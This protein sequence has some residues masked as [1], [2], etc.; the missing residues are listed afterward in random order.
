MAKVK[1][2]R[3]LLQLH[4]WL[5]RR[6]SWLEIHGSGE[7][8][9]SQSLEA[10]THDIVEHL[11]RG[12]EQAHT[13]A[14]PFGHLA[15]H[16]WEREHDD[17]RL[18]NNWE[19]HRKMR[20]LRERIGANR[21]IVDVFG[22]GMIGTGG[23]FGKRE[24]EGYKYATKKDTVR[25]VNKFKD[26][27]EPHLLAN[28]NGGIYQPLMVPGDPPRYESHYSFSYFREESKE[29][30]EAGPF[31]SEDGPNTEYET[32]TA[33]PGQQITSIQE[34]V[35]EAV[36]VGF[37]NISF[38]KGEGISG[39][40]R[41]WEALEISEPYPFTPGSKPSALLDGDS[42]GP[43]PADTSSEGDIPEDAFFWG[44]TGSLLLITLYPD[45][46]GPLGPLV[47][48]KQSTIYV[49]GGKDDPEHCG[50]YGGVWY[51]CVVGPGVFSF[52]P[53]TDWEGGGYF[54]YVPADF[55]QSPGPP[56]DYDWAEDPTTHEV[57]L[58]KP[59]P[60][61]P[62]ITG[63]VGEIH[64]PLKP[65]RT[66]EEA[67]STF[68]EIKD[69]PIFKE[70]LAFWERHLTDFNR[71]GAPF[72]QQGW[73]QA[74]DLISSPLEGVKVEFLKRYGIC[75][76]RGRLSFSHSST[77]VA[78]A[79]GKEALHS[80]NVPEPVLTLHS[81][82]V[83]VAHHDFLCNSNIGFIRVRISREKIGGSFFGVQSKLSFPELGSNFGRGS[84]SN[85]TWV[86]LDGISFP[87]ER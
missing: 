6:I 24:G 65:H 87:Y 60:E 54:A 76:L 28:T 14:A 55:L 66:F 3:D 25:A 38:Y 86:D 41:R 63:G 5:E 82:E 78:W 9:Q 81:S 26:G 64:D 48:S 53:R 46:F 44:D 71:T 75:H 37:F 39:R 16:Y 43:H 42:V 18:D 15:A 32:R 20:V 61:T 85:L 36:N 77:P 49:R 1:I 29:L 52:V 84:S 57:T 13:G 31:E 50:V 58:P 7:P 69:E 17:P 12:S 70:L 56:V 67:I 35:N 22:G 19:F 21:P 83:E 2:P 40:S 27:G 23:G 80:R 47:K 72:N 34:S 8:G 11:F 68:E 79:F 74:A 62:V 59:T 73:E 4:A 30:G 33:G 10:H 45:G 51:K